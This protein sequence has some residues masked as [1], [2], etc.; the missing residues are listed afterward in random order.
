ME[1]RPGVLL[2]AFI[3]GVGLTVFAWAAGQTAEA[4]ITVTAVPA[5]VVVSVET[6]SSLASDLGEA[7]VAN[8]FAATLISVSGVVVVRDIAQSE[9]C[10]AAIVVASLDPCTQHPVVTVRAPTEEADQ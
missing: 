5:D 6:A 8:P 3:A 1:A 10:E 7:C 9:T 4:P 2:G